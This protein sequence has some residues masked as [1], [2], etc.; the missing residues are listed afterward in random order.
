MLE[1]RTL[2]QAATPASP[3]PSYSGGPGTSLELRRPSAAPARRAQQTAPAAPTPRTTHHDAR[4]QD[5]SQQARQHA[6]P[7]GMRRKRDTVGRHYQRL[8]GQGAAQ[9]ACQ[10]HGGSGAA[11][12]GQQGRRAL[13]AGA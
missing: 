11:K 10:G 1:R 3:L 7:R 2:D 8:G 4:L 5:F 9:H 6:R 13:A 12:A